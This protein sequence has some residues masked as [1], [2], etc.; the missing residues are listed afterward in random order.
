V[1]QF[2]H[3]AATLTNPNQTRTKPELVVSSGGSPPFRGDPNSNPELGAEQVERT[4][5]MA[6][7]GV[8]GQISG[9]SRDSLTFA[10]ICPVSRVLTS[11][12]GLGTA[13]R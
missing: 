4:R 6:S 9:G 12:L 13:P 10:P 8:G 7:E 2:G 11:P 3:L 5:T 1:S